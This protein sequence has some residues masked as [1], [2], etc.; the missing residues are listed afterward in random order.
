MRARYTFY[1]GQSFPDC[2]R[3]G[4][5]IYAYLRRAELGHWDEEVFESLL[6]AGLLMARQGAPTE[7]ALAL[8]ERA[9]ATVPGRVEALD[10]AARVCRE[11]GAHALGLAA[12]ERGLGL[13]RP[14]SGLFLRPWV[15]E[16]GLLDEYAV[17][18]YWT[19]RDADC[20]V[21]CAILLAR[22][23]LEADM[24]RRV[25]ANRDFALRRLG[26]HGFPWLGGLAGGVPRVAV[27]T[28]YG[29][30]SPETL[31]RCI[32][33]VGRQTL[34][35]D[36]ILVPEGSP[37]AWLDAANVRHLALG[38]EGAG[39]G[40]AARAV[41]GLLAASAGYA[42]IAFLDAGCWFDDD[43]VERCLT[44]AVA[45]GLDRCGG[46]AATRRFRR[47]DLSTMP[48]RDEDPAAFID[49]SCYLFLPAGFGLIARWAL[50][51]AA[52]APVG[53]RLFFLGVRASGLVTGRPRS[54]ASV[55]AVAAYAVAYE[56]LGEAPPADARTLP[57]HAGH[58]AW[59]EA[60][61]P[62]A[63]ATLRAQLGIDVRDLYE[64]S[65]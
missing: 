18:A 2:G 52:L 45:V 11:R 49:A 21:A 46:V 60:L 10:A 37:Q 42:A 16:T 36:H 15:Y 50:I 41:G 56:A 23:D 61:P 25:V 28:P 22:P 58:R 38:P 3:D 62:E 26:A 44:A 64:R 17:N 20:L 6:N 5:A 51:P 59:V 31:R 47:P 48:L 13:P 65:G 55:N 57:D 24:R 33:S 34:A 30:Q 4:P 9:T 27:V 1:L 53:D 32:D 29:G 7:A 14:D 39:G 40:G 19:G 8:F 43:H 35:A 54:G 12:A 63:V